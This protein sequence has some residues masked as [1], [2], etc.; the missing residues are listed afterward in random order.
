MTT[1][2]IMKNFNVEKYNEKMAEL[3]NAIKIVNELSLI[4][5]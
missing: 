5:I 2:K 3:D 4:H 1:T